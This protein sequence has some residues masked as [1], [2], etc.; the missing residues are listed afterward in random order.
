MAVIEGQDSY[1]L[2]AETDP[3]K[4]LSFWEME[5][6]RRAR[7]GTAMRCTVRRGAPMGWIV[8]WAMFLTTISNTP[9]VIVTRSEKEI[10]EMLRTVLCLV[11]I[12]THRD[13][14]LASSPTTRTNVKEYPVPKSSVAGVALSIYHQTGV[15]GNS[16]LVISGKNGGKEIKENEKQFGFLCLIFFIVW[17]SSC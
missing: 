14:W 6:T 10:K 1:D 5:R 9:V 17:L 16:Q 12:V 7:I 11:T 15:D 4:L 13:W 3:S 8:G 2:E